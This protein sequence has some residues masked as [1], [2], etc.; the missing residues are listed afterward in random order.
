[1]KPM[2]TRKRPLLLTLCAATLLTVLVSWDF[3]PGARNT[4][5]QTDTTPKNRSEVTN[6]DDAI[7]ALDAAETKV[8]F[9]QIR[10]NVE[11]ALKQVK[12]KEFQADIEKAMADAKKAL[13]EVDWQKIQAEVQAAM[14]SLDM[15]KIKADIEKVNEKEMKKLAVEMK[16]VEEE[17]KKVQPEI[18]K[19]LVEAKKEIEKAKVELEAAREK[20]KDYQVVVDGLHEAGL[21]DKNKDYKVEAKDGELFINGTKADSKVADKYRTILNK[22]KN[23]RVSRSSDSFTIHE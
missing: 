9:D 13:Q 23:F 6:I 17:L 18:D 16:K 19:A 21:I 8:D 20:L 1:M 2:P 7:A 5:P 4:A 22:Y 15:E 11:D 14:K 10:A 3:Q 12:S